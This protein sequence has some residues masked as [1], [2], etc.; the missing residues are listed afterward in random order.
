MRIVITRDPDGRVIETGLNEAGDLG[1]LHCS[2]NQ[3]RF[4][5]RSV[6]INLEASQRGTPIVY[7]SRPAGAEGPIAGF[8]F[9][10]INIRM[11]A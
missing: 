8:L 3:R 1:W 7:D 11:T 9:A 10:P 2:L 5:A 6:T 4:R